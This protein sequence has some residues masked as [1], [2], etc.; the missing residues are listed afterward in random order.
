VCVRRSVGNRGE[1]HQLFLLGQ[2]PQST[3]T[4]LLPTEFRQAMDIAH[5]ERLAKQLLQR[6]HLAVDRCVAVST[7]AKDADDFVE[8]LLTE[9]RKLAA[10]Q[11][12]VY[13]AQKGRHIVFVRSGFP[14]DVAIFG[15][16]RLDA[17]L[18]DD[19]E[20]SCA[21]PPAGIVLIAERRDRTHMPGR[22]NCRKNRRGYMK[23]LDI[24]LSCHF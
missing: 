18:P 17:G 21:R 8:C 23:R 1:E 6:R 5:L 22:L 9:G 10:K 20:R 13:L 16:Q 24:F 3:R 4:L 2:E 15:E 14:Q 12:L 19:L 7:F 11:D